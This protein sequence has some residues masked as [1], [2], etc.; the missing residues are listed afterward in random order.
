VRE[1]TTGLLRCPRC[2]TDGALTL[3]A[4]ESDEREVREGTLRCAACDTES[5]VHDGIMHLLHDPPGF[6]TREAAGLER[7]ADR[8]RADGWDRERVLAL[9]DE[10]QDYWRGQ[11]AAIDRVLEAEDFQPGERL[12]D[13]GS[14]TCW[15]S[16]ILARR[17]LEVIALDIA[18]TEM[19]GLKTADWFIETGEVFFERMLSLMNEPA[20]AAESVDY[21]FCCEVLHHNDSENL[22]RTLAELH[23]IL[24]PGG[25]LFIV[26]EP[27]RF[28]L[29]PK[30]RHAEEVEEYEGNEHVYFFHQ[31]LRAARRAGFHVARPWDSGWRRALRWGWYHAIRGDRAL[32]LTCT[33]PAEILKGGQT[34][35]PLQPPERRSLRSPPN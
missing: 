25:T 14:N 4:K 33:K 29:R 17:G 15:A 10:D 11:R 20:L 2:L 8:M 21:V 35:P 27:M 1:A 31:Y 23:R 30:R 28:P 3:T 16:N 22:S 12:V 9:P 18:T 7:F 32:T 13:V 6:V 5:A 24:K 34:C 19:Q 26:N